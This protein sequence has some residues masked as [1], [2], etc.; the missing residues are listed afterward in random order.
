MAVSISGPQYLVFTNSLTGDKKAA[1]SDRQKLLRASKSFG[2]AKVKA[3]DGKW[4]VKG[5]QSSLYHHQVSS[6]SH[7]RD[8]MILYR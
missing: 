5:M 1:R 3:K 8:V 2:Y 6:A 4:Q 7:F